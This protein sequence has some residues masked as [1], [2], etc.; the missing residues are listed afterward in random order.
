MLQEED[1]AEVGWLLYSTREMD[2]GALADEIADM[3]GVNVGLR[4]KTVPTGSKTT[5]EKTKVQALCIEVPAKQ[6]WASQKALLQLYSRAIKR[7][8]QYPN[9]IQMRFVKM[10]KDAI[11]MKEKSKLDKL[12][13]RQKQ[14]VAGICTHV[15]YDIFQLDYSSAEGEIP[16]LR[17]MI[18]SI[19]SK[20]D[21][22]TPLFHCVDMDWQQEGFTFQ[23]SANAKDEAETVIH[24][25]LP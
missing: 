17:Q 18:M 5:T 25:L 10:K 4:W 2:A 3:I 13:E 1:S 24:T 23:F 9:G 12:R 20:N 19:T 15:N 14:F 6:K 11:N 16:T 8:D 7:V 22:V 21:G